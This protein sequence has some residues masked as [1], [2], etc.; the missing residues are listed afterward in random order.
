MEISLSVSGTMGLTWPIWN[1]LVTTADEL[2]FAAIYCSD[3]L[4][5]ATMDGLDAILALVHAAD[6]TQHIRFGPLVAPVSYRDP[7]LLARQAVLLDHLSGG[8]MILGIGA[9]W[10]EAEH[11]MF[12]YDLGSVAMRLDRL[13]EALHVITSLLRSETPVTHQGRFYRLQEAML[14]TRPLQPHRPR[15]LIGAKGRHRMLPLVAR[16]ADIWNG[17]GLSVEEFRETSALLDELLTAVDQPPEA[18]K[19]TVLLPVLCGRSPAEMEMQLRAA[20]PFL[21]DLPTHSWDAM[22][23]ALRTHMPTLIA[24]PPDA[25]IAGLHAYAEA[26]AEDLI[27][28]WRGLDDTE[29]LTRLAEEVVPH[30]TVTAA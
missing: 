25:V 9:G 27:I 12:G 4:I 1:R 10:L 29:G 2:G 28:H 26:G 14:G 15:L 21:P 17:D 13:E 5:P 16:Y 20:R 3:H 8:R 7:V 22:L 19:R 24:G 30:V 11:T 6:H 18:V 23:A